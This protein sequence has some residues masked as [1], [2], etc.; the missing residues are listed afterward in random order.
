MV[1]GM[2]SSRPNPAGGLGLHQKVLTGPELLDEEGG[3]SRVHIQG[4]GGGGGFGVADV[5]HPF[6]VL[7][8]Y[9]PA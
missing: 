7:G 4:A 9:R 5:L 8:V 6:A 1:K 3:R 2:G